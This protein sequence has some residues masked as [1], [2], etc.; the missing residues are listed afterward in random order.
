MGGYALEKLQILGGGWSVLPPGDKI[1]KQSLYLAQ[2]WRVDRFGKLV[3]RWGYGQKFSIS[4]E[5]YAHSGANNGGDETSYYIAANNS[6]GS[7]SIYLNGSSSPLV[8]GLSGG[9]VGFASMLGW[10]FIMDPLQQVR[11]NG[12]VVRNWTVAAPTTACTAAAGSTNS[13]GPNVPTGDQ[14]YQFYV[15]YGTAD[16]F[17]ETGPGPVSGS[18]TVT[19]SNINFTGVPTS[20]DSSVGYRYIYAIG[21]TL[22]SAYRVATIPDNSTTTASWTTNDLYV[23]DQGFVMPV[24]RTA[25]P[26]GAGL[27]GPY[28]GRLYT[29]VHNRLYY[30]PPGQPQYW[31]TDSILGDWVD[32][33]MSGENIQW[34][35]SHKNVLMIYKEKSVWRLVGDPTSG[36]LERIEDGIGLCNP[37]AI[38]SGVGDIDYFVSPGGLRVC[39]MDS[40]AE[41]APELG[42]LWDSPIPTHGSQFLPPGS[43][44]PGPGWL[45]ATNSLDAYAVSLGYAM[46]KLYVSY[47]ELMASGSQTNVTLVWDSQTN[48]WMY[49]R[50]ALG[51]TRFYGFY[52]D[53]ALMIGLSGSTS[54]SAAVGYSIDD[55]RLFYTQD[56]SATSITCVYQSHY[57]D[58]GLPDNQKNWIEV[59]VDYTLNGDTGGVSVGYDNGAPAQIGTITGS[60]TRQAV[61][62]TLGNTGVGGTD[63]VLA[64]NIS[65]QVFCVANAQVELH[66]VYLYYY[67]EARFAKGA[68]TIASDLGSTHAKQVKEVIVDISNPN[69]QVNVELYSDLPGN[70]LQLNQT[71]VIPTSSTRIMAKIPLSLA[72]I[73]MGFLW[74]VALR[75]GTGGPFQLYSVRLLMRPLGTY[76]LAAE[77]TGGFIWDSGP[78]TFESGITHIPRA[79]AIALAALPI[80]RFR[81][82]TLEIETFNSNVTLN[83]LTDLPGNQLTSQFTQTINTGTAGRRFVRVPLPA[84]TS[85]EIEGRMC[86]LQLSGSGSYILYDA[87]VE[88]LA[89]GVYIEDYEGQG[90]ALYD[91]R[92]VDFGSAKVKEA[93]E[94]EVDLQTDSG[95]VSISLFSDLPGFSMVQVFTQSVD[96]AGARQKVRVPLTEST[97]P[98]LYPLGRMFQLMVASRVAFRLYGAKLKVRELGTYL[99]TDEAGLTPSGMW[100]GTPPAGVWDSTPL[101]LGTERMK[102]FKKLE[103]EIQTDLLSPDTPATLTLWTDLET[104]LMSQQFTTTIDTH[105]ARASV[106]IPLTPGIRGRLVQVILSGVGVR[107]FNG[108]IWARP[109]NEPKAEWQWFPLPIEPTPPQWQYMPFPV[110]PTEAQWF[111][112]R[113]L[114]VEP[115]PNEW[116]VVDVPFEVMGQ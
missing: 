67:P 114:N 8:T 113:V 56:E 88:V 31:N 73:Q 6:S 36:T 32:V 50:N 17:Y 39:N 66:N 96:T 20:P 97:A 46:G 11:H 45:A 79:Y 99:T 90:G 78:L 91:S 98:Y 80:K 47:A 111:W 44:M 13:N 34:C 74:R 86:Q 68:S 103:F 15:T 115:T 108:R 107:L 3:S 12:S 51:L 49:H 41:F 48:K 82:I 21:A 71:A 110:N 33:G 42:P 2:N 4:G 85:T 77:S 76:V 75:A 54:G 60:G 109:L 106:K 84:G 43:V 87:A 101:D 38:A 14:P 57:E 58:C 53:G 105:G 81:E 104:G 83:F 19:N 16:G 26:A 102:E 27:A 29:W 52:F 72:P 70:T 35:T 69:G 95:P 7:C 23:T 55:Y 61:S 30:T 9:R 25:A 93:R 18:L 94:I 1:P 5:A 24:T 22:E 116:S 92:E 10:M 62:F 112:A 65:V 89:I 37:L 63:G 59:V 28:L 100:R 40:T 64:K